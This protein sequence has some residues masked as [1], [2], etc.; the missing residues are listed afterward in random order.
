MR[1][2]LAGGALLLA[3]IG[4]VAWWWAL[5]DRRDPVVAIAPPPVERARPPA[6]VGAG[7]LIPRWMVQRGVPPRRIAGRVLV[8][9]VPTAGAEVRLRAVGFGDGPADDVVLRSGPDGRF[10]FGDR[11]AAQYLIAATWPDRAPAVR[12]FDSTDPTTRLAPDALVLEPRPCQ[13]RAAGQVRDAS[14]GPIAGATLRVARIAEVTSDAQGRYELC[15]DEGGA[16]VRVDA[17]GYGSVILVYDGKGRTRRD[18]TLV[19][20]G[21]VEGRV[22]H[23]GAGV[24]G[25]LVMASPFEAGSERAAAVH[26]FTAPDGEFQLAGLSAGRYR[27]WAQAEGLG[28]SESGIAVVVPGTAAASVV[29][30]LER[31]VEV[32]GRVVRAGKPVPGVT[33]RFV[34]ADTP[35]YSAW[36]TSQADGRF[37]VRQVTPGRTRIE[38]QEHR[39]RAP[40]EVEIS[41]QQQRPI[42]V[43][44]T[45]M[46]RLRGRILRS[47]KPVS[48]EAFIRSGAV[49]DVALADGSYDLGGLAAGDNEIEAVAPSVG[50]FVSVTVRLAEGEVRD[51]FDIELASGGIISGKV[52]D[53]AD[54]PL[55]GARVLWTHV[56]TGDVGIGTTDEDGAFV[57]D[58]MTGGGLYRVQVFAGTESSAPLPPVGPAHPT[59]T[60]ADGKA[61]VDGI[62][63]SVRNERHAIR[64]RVIDGTGAPIA[65]AQVVAIPARAGAEPVFSTKFDAPATKSDGEGSF[66]IGDLPS[67]YYALRAYG[68][69]G[70][71]GSARDVAAPASGVFV[72]VSKPGSVRVRLVGYEARVVP[73]LIVPADGTSKLIAAGR[74]GTAMSFRADGVP[75]GK[76][77][78]AAQTAREGDA[79]LIDV[80][81]GAETEVTLESRGSGTIDGVVVEAPSGAPVAGMPCNVTL[82]AGGF[83]GQT[84]WSRLSAPT[85]DGD[86]RFEVARAPAGEFQVTCFSPDGAVSHGQAW[87]SLPRDGKASVRM[88][89]VR[90]AETRER[91]STGIVID[92]QQVEPRV[93]RVQPG[94]PAA[95]ADV[96]RGDLLISV[97]GVGLDGL[98]PM[99]AGLLLDNHPVGATISIGLSRNGQTRTVALAVVAVD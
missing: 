28:L 82:R 38:A 16:L 10:D 13:A 77:V 32:E 92:G 96:R 62:K 44:V 7:A 63:L 23:G 51:D 71:E 26:T 56:G 60:L 45:P 79:A 6:R 65:D 46:G 3:L 25:A 84:Q 55:A 49:R 99:G 78:V 88:K 2:R 5:A 64:G 68:P 21:G 58:S 30:E 9:G 52:V 95:I 42:E 80:R 69:G 14:G 85:T 36:A 41:S 40:R 57:C 73:V 93:S 19:P 72:T 86:G 18:L 98:G 94:T 61:R 33:L 59:V 24:G 39:V 90:R 89:V 70:A 37:V 91:G 34:A 11:P 15:L 1:R 76:Y 75:P 66:A 4:G 35:T 22:R 81:S 29:L 17:S 8:D 50:A 67:G 43:E 53:E 87:G 74:E 31:Q 27:L 12:T 47:G 48:G 97:D 54:A 20:E 83:L